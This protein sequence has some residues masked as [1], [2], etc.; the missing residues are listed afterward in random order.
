MVYGNLALRQFKDLDLLIRPQDFEAAQHILIEKGFDTLVDLGWEVHCT[1]AVQ[2][3]SVDLHRS[4]V[5][6]FF[7]MPENFID[8]VDEVLSPE[9]L[10][11][12][13]AIQLG[14]DCCHW[15]V[16]IGQLCDIAALLQT[17]PSLDFEAVR[18]RAQTLGCSRFL[19]IALMLTQDF[20]GDVVPSSMQP[21]LE[22]QE[23][24]RALANWVT[25][26]IKAETEDPS[27][28]P[29]DAGFWYFFRIYNHR[30]YLQVRERPR[31]K[32]LYCAHWVWRLIRMSFRPNQADRAL[33]SLPSY[34]AFLYVPIHMV[35]LLLK[36]T[37]KRNPGRT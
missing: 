17:Y 29:D 28:V 1:S 5:P 9:T 19:S 12:L 15:K 14:K 11:L 27:V 10:L 26:K 32:I 7:G 6:D 18:L 24:E 4:I 23:K 3:L 20:L 37:P 25:Q 22:S 2:R 36:Y 31:D 33:V 35:R 16:R 30:F 8:P 13:L 21:F 34:L